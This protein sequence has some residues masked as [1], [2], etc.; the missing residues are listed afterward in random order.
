MGGPHG[1]EMGLHKLSFPLKVCPSNFVCKSSEELAW[2]CYPHDVPHVDFPDEYRVKRTSG[3]SR[4][5][6]QYFCHEFTGECDGRA[7]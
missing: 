6:C 4:G 1:S 5:S 7:I 2:V 3:I